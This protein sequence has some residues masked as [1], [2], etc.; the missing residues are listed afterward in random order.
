[1]ARATKLEKESLEA[2]VDLCEQRYNNLELRLSKIETKVEHIHADITN[3]NKSMTKVLI[4]SAGTIVAG[5][6]ST[7]IVILL[8]SQ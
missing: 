4:G 8:N 5:L 1:M 2:H 3:N 6:L 7:I